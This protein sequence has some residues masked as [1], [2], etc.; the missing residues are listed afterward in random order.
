MFY[1]TIFVAF[2]DSFV[3]NEINKR[4][5]WSSLAGPA[6]A[7]KQDDLRDPGVQELS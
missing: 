2:Y 4:P 7:I 5:T 3:K 1:F 6:K